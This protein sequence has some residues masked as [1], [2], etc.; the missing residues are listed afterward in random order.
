MCPEL[1]PPLKKGRD[2]LEG[3][4][5]GPM[6]I[7]RGLEQLLYEK[8]LSKLSLFSRGKRRLGGR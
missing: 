1:A 5:P 2:L 8:R 7:I 3:V 6:K 4:Q